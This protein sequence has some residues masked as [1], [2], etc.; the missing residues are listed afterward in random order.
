MAQ[1]LSGGSQPIPRPCVMSNVCTRVSLTPRA[2]KP[3]G[4]VAPQ[5]HARASG[6][7]AAR[8]LLRSRRGDDHLEDVA[9]RHVA[10][11]DE[12][13][14]EVGSDGL[15]RDLSGIG[16]KVVDDVGCCRPAVPVQRPSAD[17]PVSR[18]V[19]REYPHH[20]C[21][22]LIDV[23]AAHGTHGEEPSRFALGWP[24]AGIKG[25]AGGSVRVEALLVALRWGCGGARSPVV[26]HAAVLA[27]GG[28]GGVA[29]RQ[30][31]SG[32]R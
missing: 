4:S 25:S 30:R 32:H 18:R 19:R 6:P 2:A 3:P 22:G 9:R 29:R 7:V 8:A 31:S 17:L 5:C 14:R 11:D 10:V 24:T 1:S 23:S 20:L 13:E 21:H 28:A 15:S 12:V 27:P 26:G 16:D